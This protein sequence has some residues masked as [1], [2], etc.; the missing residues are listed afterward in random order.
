MFAAS[1]HR[2]GSL[3]D[4]LSDQNPL[5]EARALIVEA[6]PM[7]RTEAQSALYS[8]GGGTADIALNLSSAF[9]MLKHRRYAMLLVDYRL[10][11]GDGLELLDWVD[12]ETNAIMLAAPVAR[13]NVWAQRHSGWSRPTF[14]A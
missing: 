9:E 8:S 13:N 2:K 10:P 6:D 12:D 7:R 5:R 14:P 3:T 4:L 1:R 11:D